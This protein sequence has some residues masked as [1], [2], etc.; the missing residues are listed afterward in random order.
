MTYPSGNRIDYIY[1]AAGRISSLT[2]AT[3]SGSQAVLMSDIIYAPFG[4]VQGWKWGS[5]DAY[6]RTFDLDGRVTSYPLGSA[7]AGGLLRTLTYDA[8]SRITAFTHV[9]LATGAAAPAYDQS[10]S[11]DNLSRLTGVIT[12]NTT[13]GYSY[14]ASGNRTKVQIGA[15]SYGYS[16]LATSNRLQSATGPQNVWG[17]YDAAG[18][19]TGDSVNSQT[20]N[21]EGRPTGLYNGS[22]GGGGYAYNGLGERTVKSAPVIPTGKNYY[23]YDEQGHLLGE[24][25]IKGVALQE[26]IYLGDLPVAVLAPDASAVTQ[27]YYVYADHINT[28]RVIT[29]AASSAIVWRWDNA[30][31]FGVGSPLEDPSGLGAFTYN[32]RFPGQLYDK[33]T[34]YFYNYYRQYNPRTGR[35]VQSDPI[36]LDGGINTYGYVEGN[37]LSGTD[38]K[39]TIVVVGNFVVVGGVIVAAVILS[40]RPG[41]KA[42][43]DIASKI[44]DMCSPDPKNKCDE[45]QDE[46]EH[47][48][49]QKYGRFF[50]WGSSAYRGCIARARTN[51]DLC[52]RGLPQIPKWNDSDVTGEPRPTPRSK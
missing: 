6:A 12:G 30:D 2:Y 36:G 46:D 41:Q 18:N 16:T 26:T 45:Q 40:S 49:G 34:G 44:S 51:A 27:A 15:A 52:S 20:Y 22:A 17:T 37:P 33:E 5:G 48:C 19:M 3:S 35:Y 4:P 23:S 13:Q 43:K 31:P 25:D 50:G 24:Y 29:A 11:Y 10:Y 39:G 42:I 38:P 32:P 9:A 28:P 47:D 1:D 21:D 7:V 14:D 8:A